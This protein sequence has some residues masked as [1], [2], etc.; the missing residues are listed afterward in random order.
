MGDSVDCRPSV[1]RQ[2]EATVISGGLTAA[3]AEGLS[4]GSGISR[5]A[6]V[7]YCTDTTLAILS[8]A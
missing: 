4:G 8:L 2:L 6:L 7:T 5:D 1:R 3:F